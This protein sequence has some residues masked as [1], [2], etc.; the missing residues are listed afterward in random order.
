[1]LWLLVRLAN[2]LT[3]N[4]QQLGESVNLHKKNCPGNIT[5]TF[6][7]YTKIYWP[8][9]ENSNKGKVQPLLSV[10]VRWFNL[11]LW[12]I[13]YL[14]S[15]KKTFDLFSC[16]KKGSLIEDINQSISLTQTM[17]ICCHF[18]LNPVW[19]LGQ[20]WDC[21]QSVLTNYNLQ[22]LLSNLILAPSAS[23]TTHWR[24][25][26]PSVISISDRPASKDTSII[27]LTKENV[28]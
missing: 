12:C 24:G 13:Q 18:K 25:W 14:T 17:K 9:T 26:Y 6:M 21:P 7:R 2:R 11:L 4:L 5:V 10:Q 19:N 23:T 1:M 16:L 27:P 22:L 3:H 28:I 20:H 15:N 8:V